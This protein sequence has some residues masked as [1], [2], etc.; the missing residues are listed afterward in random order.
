MIIIAIIRISRVHA[1]DFEIWAT[2]WQQ[3]E[4]CIAVLML[5]LT[6]FRTLYVSAKASQG[7]Q[8]NKANYSYRKRLWP[9]SKKLQDERYIELNVPGATLTGMRTV[10]AGNQNISWP[11]DRGDSEDLGTNSDDVSFAIQFSIEG[12]N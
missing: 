11:I 12:T 2:F 5:S 8:K 1:S 6:A 9:S 7:Q 10:I 3:I 4:A